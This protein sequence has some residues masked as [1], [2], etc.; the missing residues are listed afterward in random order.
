MQT[1]RNFGED[2]LTWT[3]FSYN[4]CRLVHHSTHVY[5]FVLVDWIEPLNDYISL[6]IRSNQS[7]AI[8]LPLRLVFRW[9]HNC[10][11]AVQETRAV[12]CRQWRDRIVAKHNFARPDSAGGLRRWSRS[13]TLSNRHEPCV[14]VERVSLQ[15]SVRNALL[16]GDTFLE[17]FEPRV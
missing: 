4:N 16:Q 12:R 6:A 15:N 7:K 1:M 17:L 3:E 9:K 13:Q 8:G 2:E 11:H 10:F 14:R 5:V